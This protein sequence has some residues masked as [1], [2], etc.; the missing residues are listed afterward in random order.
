MPDLLAR[1]PETV[2]RPQAAPP[3]QPS[4]LAA[5]TW[6]TAHEQHVSVPPL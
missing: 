1:A 3:V 6:H 2:A 4:L 5:K